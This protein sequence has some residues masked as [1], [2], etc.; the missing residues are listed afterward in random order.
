[1]ITITKLCIISSEKRRCTYTVKRTLRQLQANWRFQITKPA[2]HEVTRSWSVRNAIHMQQ[3]DKIEMEPLLLRLQ[4]QVV[5][6]LIPQVWKTCNH[7]SAKTSDDEGKKKNKAA[8]QHLLLEHWASLVKTTTWYLA[9]SKVLQS[10][11]QRRCRFNWWN[12]QNHGEL[13][14]PS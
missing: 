13:P 10:N 6:Y 5:I 12:Y 7:C 4:V 8:S 11:N 3:G 1:M 2:D 9:P 14:D